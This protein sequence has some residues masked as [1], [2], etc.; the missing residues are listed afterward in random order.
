MINH[1]IPSQNS[2][3]M[4]CTLIVDL[5]LLNALFFGAINFM[6]TLDVPWGFLVWNISY[7]VSYLVMP[8]LAIVRLVRLDFIMVRSFWTSVLMMLLFIV[9]NFLLKNYGISN[10]HILILAV[11]TTLVLLI[12]RLLDKNIAA[13]LRRSNHD[14]CDVV[15]LGAGVNLKMLYNTIKN[16]GTGYNVHGYF[17]NTESKNL[18]GLLPRLGNVSDLIPYLQSHKVEAIICNLDPGRA[19]EINSVITYCENHLVKFYSVLNTQNYMNRAMNLEFID[20]FPVISMRREPLTNP[21]NRGIKRVFDF[22]FSL[23]AIILLSPV[24]LITAI[25]IKISS[26]GPVFFVQ[27]RTGK[28]GETFKCFKFRSMK[29]NKDA[30]KIQATVNDPRKYPFGNF[31]RKTNLDELPQFFNVLFGSMSIVGPRP[32]MLA[33]TD[34]YGQLVDKYMVR[35]YAKPGITGWAQVT[36]SR[37]ETKELWQMEERI[38]KDI[39][40]LENWSLWLDIRIIVRTVTNVIF[41]KDKDTAF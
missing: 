10:L 20:Q 1:Q 30:D 24:M 6:P 39:W 37:G 25:I 33:H 26:P 21:F 11:S 8:P 36:G 22:V 17:E 31:M 9:G 14:N 38:R 15:F 34:Q 29:V 23:L 19:E 18:G 12:S 5:L 32:H 2:I 41:R 3:S 16:P 40:Y 4:W 7:I 27:E 35:H 28:D 13:L